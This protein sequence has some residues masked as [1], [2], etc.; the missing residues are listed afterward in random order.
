MESVAD[1]RRRLAQTFLSNVAKGSGVCDVNTVTPDTPSQRKAL[2]GGKLDELTIT[3]QLPTTSTY[4]T[5]ETTISSVPDSPRT[6]KRRMQANQFLSSLCST[7]EV[8]TT[9]ADTGIQIPAISPISPMTDSSSSLVANMN[10]TGTEET[11]S[12]QLLAKSPDL[13]RSSLKAST[14]Y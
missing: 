5:A 12:I 9:P 7:A 13:P 1:K 8:T 10:G 11:I 2:D 3:A 4:P 14:L 6:I